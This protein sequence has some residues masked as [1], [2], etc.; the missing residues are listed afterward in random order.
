MEVEDEACF[1]VDS[2]HECMSAAVISGGDMSPVLV[3]RKHVF[4][5]VALFI[6][7]PVV[8]CL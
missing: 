3:F 7:M 2:G 1:D 6:Q 5:K 4:D 8:R